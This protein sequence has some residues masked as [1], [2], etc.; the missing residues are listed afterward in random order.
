MGND[1]RVSL[2]ERRL[3]DLDGGGGRVHSGGDVVVYGIF[4]RSWL[5]PSLWKERCGVEVAGALP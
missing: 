2:L 3:G 4:F 5:P 1:I